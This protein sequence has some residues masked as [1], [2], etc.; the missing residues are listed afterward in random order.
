MHHTNVQHDTATVTSSTP[1]LVQVSTIFPFHI[2]QNSTSKSLATQQSITVQFC[3][4]IKQIMP[5]KVFSVSD[6]TAK[7][8]TLSAVEM[9]VR[10]LGK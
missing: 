8:I 3:P 4:G 10:Q 6:P 5:K 1:P 7:A 9:N 2:M